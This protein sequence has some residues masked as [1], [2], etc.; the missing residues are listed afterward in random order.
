MQ[1]SL[2]QML[3]LVAVGLVMSSPAAAI[4]ISLHASSATAP[5]NHLQTVAYSRSV[6]TAQTR[7]N[8]LG[9]DAGPEDGLMG[10][11]T[12]TAIAAY[13]RENSLRVT[14]QVDQELLL[15]ME[16]ND[17]PRNQQRA[18][19]NKN[20]AVDPA[21]R[22][23]QR[24][25]SRLGYP[26]E[27]TGR[28]DRQ[29]Q[30]GIREYQR[31]HDLFVT[32]TASEY[33]QAHIRESA[34]Q[35]RAER[36]TERARAE[37]SVDRETI[38]D[39]QT[40]LQARG[41]R[42]DEAAGEMNAETEA[43]IRAYQRDSGRDVT[44]QPSDDLAEALQQ[45]LNIFDPSPEEIMQVQRELNRRGF[46]AGPADGVMGPSTR[47]A[48]REYRARAELDVSSDIDRTL[49]A[50][51]ESDADVRSSDRE[52]TG[53]TAGYAVRFKDDF[54]DG[55]FRTEPEWQVVSNQFNVQDG[56]LA[57]SVDV[58]GP[59]TTEEIGKSVLQGVLGEVLGVETGA[60]SN[61]A[62][63]AQSTDFGNAFRIKTRLSGT[64]LGAARLG[65]GPYRG[66]NVSHGYRLIYDT[67]R[68]RPLALVLL[69]DRGSRT[70]A[71]ASSAP[72]LADGAWHDVEWSRDRFGNMT[73]SVNGQTEIQVKD[74]SLAGEY[75][76]LSLVNLGGSWKVDE[77]QV[78]SRD[79]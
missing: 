15:H 52:S 63:I 6:Y 22:R 8:A 31:D 14:G 71:S 38:V 19:S 12:R 21:V 13:Q 35:Q 58:R 72:N 23:L 2:R 20:S 59:K 32:G 37:R 34:Q 64:P 49:L 9:Y 69:D 39:I 78:A 36:R 53:Q 74:Q 30:A 1:N 67:E 45:G 51:L 43:A 4:P 5:D 17:R 27:A 68:S 73:V 50:S 40:G 11:K 66:T 79:R 55:N 10:A 70:I 44:G 42:I 46:D 54:D 7:L 65:I 33:V 18:Q 3:T 61:A 24:Q 76:G 26:V 29:T 48:I 77:I 75:D 28:L 62:A 56:A 57:S 16:R 60:R 25:L 41:Y 47:K